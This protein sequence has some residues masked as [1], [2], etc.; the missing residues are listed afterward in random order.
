MRHKQDGPKAALP[1]QSS[2]LYD[3][4]SPEAQQYLQQLGDAVR[5]HTAVADDLAG[6][7]RLKEAVP[8]RA[9][10]QATGAV[11]RR[12]GAAR[13][14]LEAE[15]TSLMALRTEVLRALRE[16]EG[17]YYLHERLKTRAAAAAASVPGA[18]AQQPPPETLA[19]PRLPPPWLDSAVGRFES[20]VGAIT[21][22]A[23]ELEEALAPTVGNGG[24]GGEAEAAANLPRIVRSANEYLMRVA[25]K[26]GSVVA[27]VDERKHAFLAER[28]RAGDDTTDPFFEAECK[29]QRDAA[30]AKEEAIRSTATAV[31]GQQAPATATAAGAATP[32]GA[33]PAAA[34]GGGLFGGAPAS[35]S[36]APT[37]NTSLFGAPAAPAAAAAPATGGGAFGGATGAGAAPAAGGLFGTTAAAAPPASAATTGGGLFGSTSAAAAP[38][39]GGL[40]GAAAAPA[41]G[42]AA[43]AAGGGLF[44]STG[45]TPGFGGFATPAPTLGAP[46]TPAFGG[47]G[48]S[49]TNGGRSKRSNKR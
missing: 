27:A 11:L 21:S 22:S 3:E 29:E 44:G 46:A 9:A 13:A 28:R 35:A 34:T 39:A 8:S 15:A 36:A 43:P 2:T 25:A 20:E 12:A 17:A 41:S 18:P 40:F 45:A 38:A 33:T 37:A 32:A 7:T 6:L 10:R 47:G 42:A 14:A 24:V 30:R 31:S 19:P 4:L 48:V 49:A 23:D 1:V 5:K 26:V 16:A